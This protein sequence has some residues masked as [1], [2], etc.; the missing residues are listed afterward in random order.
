MALSAS[1]PC[2]AAPTHGDAGAVRAERAC[3]WCWRWTGYA[4]M[5]LRVRALAAVSEQTLRAFALD[6]RIKKEGG[7]EEEER[8]KQTV[9]PCPGSHRASTR[10]WQ[11]RRRPEDCHLKPGVRFEASQICAGKSAA[12]AQKRKNVPVDE[13]I[14]GTELGGRWWNAVV[15]FM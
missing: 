2:A 4:A 7:G 6:E 9:A 12:A 5:L 10:R 8:E 11:R 1:P 3:G 14:I 13:T 15:R